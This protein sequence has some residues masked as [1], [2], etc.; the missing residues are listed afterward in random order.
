IEAFLDI[1]SAYRQLST[2]NRIT[3][4]K[5]K[6]SPARVV[7][8]NGVP[9]VI[10]TAG[11]T[12][13]MT[14]PRVSLLF[15]SMGDLVTESMA[16]IFR[17]RGFNAKA[18][19]PA[20]ETILK[21][22]RANTS[23]KECL[24]LILTTG[25][26]LNYIQNK[27]QEAEVLVYFM[28]TGSGPCRFGQYYIFMEDLVRKL[29][30]P[31][32]ALLAL[33]SDNSYTGLGNGFQKR[34]WWAIIISD[35]M[36]DIR[37]ML[38]ANSKE[39]GTAM[40]IFDREWHLILGELE[41]GEFNTLNKQLIRT[42]RHFRQ[43]P[44]KRPS[45]QVPLISLVGEIFVRRDQLSRQYLTE[46]LADKGFATI[47]SPIAEW[48]LYS[49]YTLQNDPSSYKM[50]KKEKLGFLIKKISMTRFEKKIKSLLSISGLVHA[51]PVNIKSIIANAAPYI[52]SDLA[53]EA[54]LTVGSAMT[55]IATQ[56]CG[57]ISIGPFGCMPNRLSEALLNKAMTR[58]GKLETDP[59]NKR[60]KAV[61]TEMDDLPFLAIETDGSS[62][63]QLITAKLESFCLRAGRLHQQMMPSID[64]IRPSGAGADGK[65]PARHLFPR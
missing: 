44:L 15:P 45:N 10:T 5:R 61:L 19:P 35:V 36:E 63:P 12:L 60:L 57:V 50:L 28:P 7:F 3:Q 51:T 52:T 59:R 24:P 30:I 54:I 56:A 31:D 11:K 38:L 29:G 8:G 62:F 6:F 47:C 64:A 1:V 46:T 43:I 40:D 32:V 20:D 55:E 17:G 22:G 27:K 13:S 4:K 21:L 49:D 41:K 65:S 42:A 26:L 39:I 2:Q 25:T 58:E 9:K 23:C 33:T 14:D 48:M 16:A 34:G 37:S 18:H 53:G